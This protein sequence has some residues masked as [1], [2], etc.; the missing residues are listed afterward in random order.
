MLFGSVTDK[1]VRGS[2]R[3]VLVLRGERSG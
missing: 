2:R 3:D 1:V